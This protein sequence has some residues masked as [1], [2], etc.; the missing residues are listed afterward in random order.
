M[1]E[2]IYRDSVH[3]IINID[4][5]SDEGRLQIAL[6]DT[7]EFQRLTSEAEAVAELELYIAQ[8]PAARDGDKI[9]QTIAD[10]K[11]KVN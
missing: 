3:N 1:P 6:I 9:K 5:G 4:T 11:S 8:N 7:P 10:L 2:R